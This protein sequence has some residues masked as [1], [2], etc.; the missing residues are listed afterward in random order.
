MP[1]LFVIST[2]SYSDYRVVCAA[3]DEPTAVALAARIN[4]HPMRFHDEARV[5]RIP[6]VGRLDELKP[7]QLFEVSVEWD[8][9]EHDRTT[10]Y[11]YP[12]DQGGVSRIGGWGAFGVSDRGYDEALKAARDLASTEKARRE[13]IA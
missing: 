4:E 2:G 1:D 7:V 6:M 3:P 5:E 10:Y 9:T 12:W 13:G 8:G 11:A